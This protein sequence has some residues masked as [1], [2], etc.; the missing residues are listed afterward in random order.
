MVE[1]FTCPRRM[2]DVKGEDR[3]ITGRGLVSQSGELSCSYCGSL[4]PDTFMYWLSQGGEISPTDKNYKAYIRSP[5]TNGEAKFYY[6]HL[7]DKQKND[8]VRILND[9]SMNII[10]PGFFYQPPFFM[11]YVD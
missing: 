7:S 4:N 6:P 1:Q 3:W 5:V 9:G 10:Y 2:D 11:K 8:F